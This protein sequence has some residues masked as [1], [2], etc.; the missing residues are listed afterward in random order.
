VFREHV[1]IPEWNFNPALIN[2][3]RAKRLIEHLPFSE[4]VGRI[5][6]VRSIAFSA[7]MGRR[8]ARGWVRALWV[9]DTTPEVFDLFFNSPSGY[10]A[11]FYIAADRGLRANRLSIDSVQD[12]L[13][14]LAEAYPVNLMTRQQVETSLASR[15]AK[16]WI[17]ESASTVNKTSTDP[18]VI[19]ALEVPRWVR[20]MNEAL[21]AWAQQRGP[22]PYVARSLLGV[23]APEGRSLK[24]VGAWVNNEIA[25]HVVHSK[26][27]R[28]EHIHKFGFS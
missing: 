18:L 14:G 3:E 5:S 28:A 11:Q 23:Q 27:E 19:Q 24:I 25:D 13:L 26:E 15:Y 12:R 10:R 21:S 4:L 6:E 7:E 17:D 20:A 9:I 1:D 8:D 16:I 2:A 22:A